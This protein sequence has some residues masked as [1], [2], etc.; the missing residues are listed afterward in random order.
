M[1]EDIE[2]IP[3]IEITCECGD[4]EAFHGV[5]SKDRSCLKPGCGCLEFRRKQAKEKIVGLEPL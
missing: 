2:L 3:I 4:G 1:S 5:V